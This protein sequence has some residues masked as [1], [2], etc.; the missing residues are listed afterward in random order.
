MPA[1]VVVGPRQSGKSTLVRNLFPE[2]PYVTLEPLDSRE[3]ATR[4]PRAFLS[5]FPNGAIIDEVQ[6]VPTLFSY[7]QSAMDEKRRVG[8]F[9][10]T[11][12]QHFLLMENVSQ[13]LAGRI[14]VYELLPF[15]WDELPLEKR[16]AT[17]DEVLLHGA[18]PRLFD[19]PVSSQDWYSAYI[20]TYVER[21]VRQMRNIGNLETFQRFLKLCAGRTGQ[22]LNAAS[23]ASDVGVSPVTI[24]AWIGILKA[25]FIIHLVT[26]HHANFNKRII[27]MPK[28]YFIDTG[29]AC[30]LLGIRTAEVLETHPLRGALFETWVMGEFLKHRVHQGLPAD[31]HFWR[32]Q[33]GHEVDVLMPSET[34]AT[35]IPIEIKSSQTVQPEMARDLTY[36]RKLAA[37]Q[38]QPGVVVYGGTRNVVQDGIH[39]VGW[40]QAPSLGGDETLFAPTGPNAEHRLKK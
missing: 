2:K 16:P 9:V 1:V 5:R 13:S 6:R 14:L 24:Q 36:W 33:T 22:L 34:Q 8:L 19:S 28:L 20:Q 7:L 25:S 15:A 29:L 11:G 23:L 30:S 39:F 4:D 31:L 38:E 17:L 27:K 3:E 37:A 21:D 10:L 26:P 18:Y 40:R 12:S 35:P 32:D